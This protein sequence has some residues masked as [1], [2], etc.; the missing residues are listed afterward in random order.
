MTKGNV[1]IALQYNPWH[2]L[3]L[4]NYTAKKTKN[5]LINLGHLLNEANRTV[6]EEKIRLDKLG[7]EVRSHQLFFH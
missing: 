3:Q 4:D 7:K 2:E 1:L 6:N 5:S